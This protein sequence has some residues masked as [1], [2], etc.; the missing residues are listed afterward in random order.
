MRPLKLL[1]PLVPP[2]PPVSSDDANDASDAAS[3]VEAKWTARPGPDLGLPPAPLPPSKFD[4]GTETGIDVPESK[5]SSS[6]EP[7]P[8]TDLLLE[9]P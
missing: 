1:L 6:S 9:T 2:V 3:S 5:L 7:R 4:D 8:L